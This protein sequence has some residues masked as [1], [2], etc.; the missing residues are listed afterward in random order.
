MMFKVQIF[1]DSLN[2]W[3]WR[4]KANIALEHKKKFSKYVV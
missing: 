4:M 1:Q 3:R 2:K